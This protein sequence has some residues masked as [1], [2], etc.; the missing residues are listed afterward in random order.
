MF[1]SLCR[2]DDAEGISIDRPGAEFEDDVAA[3]ADNAV[4]AA[5]APPDD[6]VFAADGEQ[7]VANVRRKAGWRQDASTRKMMKLVRQCRS[8]KEERAALEVLAKSSQP[9]LASQCVDV[10]F[11]DGSACDKT[12]LVSGKTL[13]SVKARKPNFRK[14]QS[15]FVDRGIVSHVEA[16]SRGLRKCCMKIL[17]TLSQSL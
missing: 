6:R 15:N 16:H 12:V 2:V 13:R 9:G 14:N 1:A 4:R 11:N 17:K 10:T 3:I 7:V 8:Q 5:P